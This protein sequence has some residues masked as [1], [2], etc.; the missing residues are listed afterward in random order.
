M[1]MAMVELC[2]GII[3]FTY[4]LHSIF[5]FKLGTS[6][7]LWISYL[8]HWYW[9]QNNIWNLNIYKGGLGERVWVRNGTIKD[10][11][12]WAQ[13]ALGKTPSKAAE[14]QV[15]QILD[16]N[17]IIIICF[18]GIVH[19]YRN[20]ICISVFGVW[21]RNSE[22]ARIVNIQSVIVCRGPLL[23]IYIGTS[24]TREKFNCSGD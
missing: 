18:V 17:W 12:I 21:S 8:E 19:L 16:G 5:K 23:D 9:N 10:G 7:G 13:R 1:M 15:H 24:T 11:L 4:S 20:N 2:E 6:T 3:R 22:Q 14:F